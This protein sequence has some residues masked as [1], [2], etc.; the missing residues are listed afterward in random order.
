MTI[1]LPDLKLSY[2]GEQALYPVSIRHNK[3]LPT[4]SFR[5][6]VTRD[7]L[8][9]GYKIP[10]ITALLGLGDE[11]LLTLKTYYMPGTLNILLFQSSLL[12]H[13]LNH[14]SFRAACCTIG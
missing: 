5:F 1:G 14:G 3:Y 7:T 10:V 11:I 12:H 6:P 8:A 13:W 2:P 4:T 9:F